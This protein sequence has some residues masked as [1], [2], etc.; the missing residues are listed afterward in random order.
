MKAGQ[1]V[2]NSKTGAAACFISKGAKRTRV[3]VMHK[4][5]KGAHDYKLWANNEVKEYF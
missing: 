4:S 3:C 2:F 1:V 5:I